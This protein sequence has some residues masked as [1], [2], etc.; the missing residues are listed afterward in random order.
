MKTW[1]FL[2][3]RVIPGGDPWTKG[4]RIERSLNTDMLDNIAR[5]PLTEFPDVE[6]AVALTINRPGVSGD[7]LV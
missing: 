7:F 4:D 1:D 2:T 6:V 5:G 3:E